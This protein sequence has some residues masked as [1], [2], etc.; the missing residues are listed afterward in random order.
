VGEGEEKPRVSVR[1][2]GDGRARRSRAARRQ[3][4]ERPAGGPH[5]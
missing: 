1:C 4:G 2:R 3:L 5:V